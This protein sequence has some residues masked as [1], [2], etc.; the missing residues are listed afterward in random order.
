LDR[1]NHPSSSFYG[2][3]TDEERRR[4]AETEAL[5]RQI[6]EEDPGY[7]DRLADR[8]IAE[9]KAEGGSIAMNSLGC[10]PPTI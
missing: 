3:I 10:Q 6:I 8:I 7:F 4:D 1:E 5:C 2:T 9:A